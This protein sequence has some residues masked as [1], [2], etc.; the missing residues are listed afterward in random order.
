MI[1]VFGRLLVNT[2]YI[3]NI[4]PYIRYTPIS[5]TTVL[6]SL[7]SVVVCHSV[8]GITIHSNELDECSEKEKTTKNKKQ[9]EPFR[10]S[11]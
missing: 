6:A 11:L 7:A 3:I 4:I 2:W 10:L 5:H 1:I 9:R 8:F